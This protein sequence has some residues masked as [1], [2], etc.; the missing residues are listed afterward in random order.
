MLSDDELRYV[1]CDKCFTCLG[2]YQVVIYP[3][4]W[5]EDNVS[6]DG[7]WNVVLYSHQYPERWWIVSSF[8]RAMD[9]LQEYKEEYNPSVIQFLLKRPEW[10]RSRL[11]FNTHDPRWY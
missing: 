8:V 4:D 2:E 6:W 9:R 10:E 7:D 11:D 5:T 1:D 3:S